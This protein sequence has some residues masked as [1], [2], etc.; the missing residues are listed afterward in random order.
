MFMVDS[1]RNNFIY[2][3]PCR[4]AS[5]DEQAQL[6]TLHKKQRTKRVQQLPPVVETMEVLYKALNNLG[7]CF[8]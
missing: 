3:A 1:K 6:P 2:K 8:R 4:F 7:G 5:D